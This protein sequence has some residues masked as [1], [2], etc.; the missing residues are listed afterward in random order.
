MDGLNPTEAGKVLV[1][2]QLGLG[3]SGCGRKMLGAECI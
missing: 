1:G 3:V 2:D